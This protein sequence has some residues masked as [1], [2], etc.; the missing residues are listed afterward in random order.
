GE[1][2]RVA[3]ARALSTKPSLILADEPTGNLDQATGA[4][5]MD[6]LFELKERTGATLLLITHDSDLATRCDR[7][8]SLADGRI[9]AN[10]DTKADAS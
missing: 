6:L 9:V 10:S 8:V 4:A 3:I 7:I 5:V 2:Q 1:Q